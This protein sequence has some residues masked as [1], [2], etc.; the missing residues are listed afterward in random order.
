MFGTDSLQGALGGNVPDIRF[1]PN[2]LEAH[3]FLS[4]S[5]NE[6]QAR[7]SLKPGCY[8]ADE[9]VASDDLEVSP[10]SRHASMVKRAPHKRTRRLGRAVSAALSLLCSPDVLDFMHT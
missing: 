9:L 4:S 5:D 1:G 10:A 7:A 2:C 6:E 8:P 3:L